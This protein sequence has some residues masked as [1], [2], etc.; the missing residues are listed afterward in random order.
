MADQSATG[1]QLS[2][3]DEIRAC[4]E[5]MVKHGITEMTVGSVTIKRPATE[6]PKQS[7]ES[8]LD[9]ISKMAPDKQD[10]A[11]MLGRLGGERP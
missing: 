5:L 1:A 3:V 9:Q 10:A 11:L 6:A 7:F 4:C 2:S 8:T